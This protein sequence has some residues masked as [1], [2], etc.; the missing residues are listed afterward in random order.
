MPLD[1]TEANHVIPEEQPSQHAQTESF[2]PPIRI[3]D[4]I[5]SSAKFALLY[6]RSYPLA[7]TLPLLPRY[8]E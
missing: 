5:G 7:A 1:P 2:F 3:S 6:S 4:A 8:H